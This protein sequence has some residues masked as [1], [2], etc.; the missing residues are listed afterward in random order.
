M[1]ENPLLDAKNR[2]V[3]ILAMLGVSVL[4]HLVYLR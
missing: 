3:H 4:L 1:H 2:S